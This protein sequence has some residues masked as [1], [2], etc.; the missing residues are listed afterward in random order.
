MRAERGGCGGGGW[1]S[2]NNEMLRMRTI[3][4]GEGKDFPN[5]R[6]VSFFGG[7]SIGLGGRTA[8]VGV[9]RGIGKTGI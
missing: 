3:S 8:G 1:D 6:H 5:Y 7:I 9:C 2:M 4:G